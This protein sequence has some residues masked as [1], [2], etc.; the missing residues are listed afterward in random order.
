MYDFCLDNINPLDI[1][2]EALWE[3]T[4]KVY[5]DLDSREASIPK[6]ADVSKGERLAQKTRT[7]M[8]RVSFLIQ[9]SLCPMYINVKP[10]HYSFEDDN[11]VAH[12]TPERLSETCIESETKNKWRVSMWQT[13][14]CQRLICHDMTEKVQYILGL[15]PYENF[16]YNWPF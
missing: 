4:L 14:N 3:L 12:Y 13:T 2:G 11:N 16:H 6:N 10:A 7:L 8:Q 1:K 5:Y 9:H 15:S